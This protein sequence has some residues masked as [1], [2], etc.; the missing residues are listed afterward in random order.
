MFDILNSYLFQHR[1]ISVPGLGSICLENLPATADFV[2]KVILPPSWHFRFDKYAD[3]PDKDFFSYLAAQKNMHDYEAIRWYNEFS[4]ELSNRI[5][6][7][8]MLRWDGVGILTRDEAGHVLFEST[9]KSPMFL[10]P[11]AAERVIRHHAEH[12][13]LVGDQ[14]RTNLEMNDWLSEDASYREKESWWI[15]ALILAAAAFLIL[16]FHFYR[17]G[18]QLDA[19]S[20]QQMISK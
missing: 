19:I 6:N 2:N 14:E 5:R 7:E 3:A 8:G 4:Y 1:S 12:A 13:L 10:Q 17:N 11:V 9:A 15:Y 16:F 18:W 20:N